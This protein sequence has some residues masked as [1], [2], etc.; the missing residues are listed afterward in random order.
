M[1][2][3]LRNTINWHPIMEAEDFIRTSLGYDD[4]TFVVHCLFNDATYGVSN[5]FKDPIPSDE[6]ESMFKDILLNACSSER[7]YIKFYCRGVIYEVGYKFCW[8][9]KKIKY[10]WCVSCYEYLD[11]WGS[12]EPKVIDNRYYQLNLTNEL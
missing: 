7:P 2:N 11:W 9:E 12:R 6:I 3:E 8:Y 10:G 5:I 4:I 1:Y